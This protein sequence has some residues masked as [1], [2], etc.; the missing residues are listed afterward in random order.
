MSSP[1]SRNQRRNLVLLRAGDSSIHECWLE[2]AGETRNW[3]F[4]INYFDDDPDIFRG[5]DWL[6][7]DSKGLK[8]QGLHDFIRAHEDLI[9]QYDFV[10]LPD[11]DLRIRCQEIN[12][13]FDVCRERK[14][15]LAQPSLTPDSYFSHPVTL[16]CPG[17]QLRYTSFVEIMAP[18]LSTDALWTV[19]PTMNGVLSGWGLDFA[20]ARILSPA[21]LVI[22]VIDEVQMT[23]TRPVGGGKFYD[24][25]KSAGLSAWDEVHSIEERYGIAE[26]RYEIHEGVLPSGRSVRNRA[27]ILGLYVLSLL[28]SMPRMRIGR[29]YLVPMFL[30][31]VWQQVK[32]RT[33][34]ERHP[35][36]VAQ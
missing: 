7:I 26:R 21:G 27:L 24:V 25:V 1:Q 13:M 36:Q 31:A 19:L 23:H 28:R 34:Q 6:R 30:S 10:W 15:K 29:R 32:R 17:F 3:D 33:Q 2:G 22:A 16:H 11:E 14:L 12:R 35:P 20:W 9:R 5:G 18:C 8:M 4:I